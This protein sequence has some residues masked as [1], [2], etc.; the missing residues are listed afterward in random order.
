MEKIKYEAFVEFIKQQI[1]PSQQQVDKELSKESIKV[2][3]DFI[4]KKKEELRTE[5][6]Y[7]GLNAKHFQLISKLLQ[8]ITL[9]YHCFQLQLP[10][11]ESAPDLLKKIDENTVIAISTSTGSGKSTLL[12]A[13]LIAEGYDRVLVTQP[14][15]LPCTSICDRV[16]STMTSNE[17]SERIAGWAVSGDEHDIKSPILYLTDGLLK[18][19]LLHDEDLITDQTK[20]NKSIVFFLDEIHERSINIDLCLALLVRLLTKKPYLQSKMKLVISSATL[21]SSVPALFLQKIKML[22]FGEFKM[23]KLGTLYPVKKHKRPNDNLITLVQELNKKR[24]RN[25]QILC[26]VSSTAEALRG[27]R[28]LQ[29][30]SSGAI[31]AYSLIQS[32]SATEQQMN[33]EHGSIFFSTTVAETSL[34]FPSLRYVIDTGMVKIPKYDLKMKQ[35]VLEKV[36]VAESTIKQ[37]LGRLGRTQPGD[38]YALYDFKVDEKKF[39]TAQIC[40]SE[41]TTIE[42]SLR[43]SPAQEDL[44]KIKKFLPD[45]PPQAAIDMALAKLRRVGVVNPAPDE[46]FTKDGDGIAKLPDLGSVEMSKAV[47]SALTRYKCG[48]DLIAIAS[49]LGVL[50]T[51][52]VLSTLPKRYKSTDGDF[53]TLLNVMNEV[54]EAEKSMGPRQ[55]KLQ[56][57]CQQKGLEKAYQTLN[58]ACRRYK[59]LEKSFSMSKDYRNQAQIQS[60]K[61]ESIAKALLEGYSDN[62]FVSLKELQLRKHQYTCYQ[63]SE[64]D[65][66][67]AVLD[68][69]STLNRSI[70]SAPVSLIVTRDI[71]RT[72]SVRAK[73]ILSFV[74]EIKPSW[75]QYEVERKIK[76]NDTEQEKLNTENILSTAKRIFPDAHVELNHNVLSIN[77]SSGSVL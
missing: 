12:P 15:R 52:D 50:N 63:S 40:Q 57:F 25:E 58:Q 32:Q 54:L 13:L 72:S 19:Q 7:E 11:F 27:P 44:N 23:P 14:R 29:E 48:R 59:T 30:V 77:G 46:S 35:T 69:H 2:L 45:E 20:L 42:L 10:L 17:D 39:P 60:G 9:Y 6:I 22:R 21:D 55:F 76:L 4:K 65:I 1:F 16:N 66:E 62:V 43:K 53:M 49:V 68:S 56:Q 37:R 51:S 47:F 70:N 38:Y 5:R 34:T 26:F 3:N 75:I 71:L 8:R 64:P 18:E 67:V 74:G 31:I 36:R 41:L 24:Q 28:L 33:I 61:W 73:A